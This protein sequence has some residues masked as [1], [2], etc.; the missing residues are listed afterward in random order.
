MSD[1]AAQPTQRTTVF[2][3]YPEVLTRENW[4]ITVPMMPHPHVLADGTTVQDQSAEGWAAT[5]DVMVDAGY[6][7]IDPTDTWIRIADLSPERLQEFAR[8][9][10]AAGLSI[11][12]F[13]TSRRSVMDHERADENLAY[14]HRAI[15]ACAAIG[16]PL[17]NFG[18]MRGFTPA[19]AKAL[20][21]WLEPG[22]SDDFS[23]EARRTAVKK[24]QELAKHAQEVGVQIALEMYEDTY[25]GTADSAVQFIHEVG[26]DNVGLNPDFGN[27]W[28]LHRPV[29]PWEEIAAKMLPHTNYWHLKNYYRDE[30]P[31]TGSVRTHPAPLEFGTINYRKAIAIAIE[32]G[33]R[34]TFCV[35]HYGG[36][37]ISVGATNREYIRRVLPKQTP[38]APFRT[39]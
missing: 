12:A 35:E 4:P 5:F 13:S 24:I 32:S 19:Q 8:T 18:F 39:L 10:R 23:D 11:P 20:W 2:D 1:D 7:S 36:D 25:L 37:S 22:Y 16:I 26:Y 14:S 3:G 31:G 29:E 34:G 33:F 30:E 28:R 38:W 9:V 27:I 17:V 15:D 21:F 6:T